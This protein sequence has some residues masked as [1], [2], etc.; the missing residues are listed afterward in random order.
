[1]KPKVIVTTS[2]DDGH[3]LDLKLA[4]LLVRHNLAATFY[5]SPED[6]EFKPSDRLTSEQVRKLSTQFEIGAHT[7]T[8]PRLPKIDDAAATREIA[9]SKTTLESMIGQKVT[10]FCYPGG[11]YNQTHVRM[12]QDAGYTYARTVDRFSYQVG[13]NRLAAPTT[14]HAYRHW[15]DLP[16]IAA[17]AGY[18]PVKTLRYLLNWDLLA[19]AMFDRVSKTGGV[20]HLWGHSWEI[21]ANNDWSRLEHVMR[22]VSG[23]QNVSY[24]VNGAL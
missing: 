15:S 17:I 4:K 3:I 1:M 12:A 5:V 6:R 9:N 11:A 24:L 22:H 7:L 18:N 14:V 2:W 10:T 23:R 8:H 20:F 16:R 13:D 21:D 19:I